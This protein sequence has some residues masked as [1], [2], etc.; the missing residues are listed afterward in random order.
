M[1]EQH[2]TVDAKLDGLLRTWAGECEADAS[3]GSV[4]LTAI[5]AA[6]PQPRS[7]AT[8]SR[9]AR[10]ALAACAVAVI[11]LAVSLAIPLSPR[12]AVPTAGLNTKV[13]TNV[14]TNVNTDINTADNTGS[15]SQAGLSE[16]WNR[17]ADVFGPQLNWLCD[18]DGELLLGVDEGAATI[19]EHDR[20]YV[21]L[22]VRVRD[23]QSGEWSAIWTGRVV[24]PLGESVDFVS[25][26]SHSGGTIWVQ[27]LPDG[28]LVA[29]H[30]LNW[31]DHP[32][33]SGSVDAEVSPGESRVVAERTA[34]GRSIQ[35]I[36]VIQQVWMPHAGLL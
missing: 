3:H 5:L 27:S 36:Q 31:P 14:N 34:D 21:L 35:V 7:V 25:H 11:L 4:L 1:N 26:K 18:L 22:T 24:C 30:W 13:N 6:A 28:R 23:T 8:S 33:I 17:T 19:V 2:D 9:G 12:S 16:L 15:A 32:E 20:A 29:S 10:F